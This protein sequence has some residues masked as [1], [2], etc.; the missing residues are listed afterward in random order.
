MQTDT[1]AGIVVLG[2]GLVVSVSI[3]LWI[4]YKRGDADAA[5]QTAGMAAGCILTAGALLP[6]AVRNSG[7]PN[8]LEAA[9]SPFLLS[10]LLILFSGP[11]S[12][13]HTLTRPAVRRSVPSGGAP[14]TARRV[15]DS[16]RGRAE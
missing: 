2:F 5:L 13:A 10:T 6:Q 9:F 3:Y 8:A 11:H 14:Q 16:P 4:K 7:D 15:Q 12:H 1:L